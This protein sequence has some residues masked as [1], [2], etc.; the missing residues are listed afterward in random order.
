M[1]GNIGL[2]FTTSSPFIVKDW[3][4]SYTQPDYA[5]TGTIAARTVVIPPGPV[6]LEPGHVA[7]HSLEPQLRKLGMPTKLN[8]GVPTLE[9]EYEICKEGQVLKPDQVNLLKLFNILMAQ[10]SFYALLWKRCWLYGYKVSN[11]TYYL[12]RSQ[13]R[14][15]H[16]SRSSQRWLSSRGLD[17]S[18][19]CVLLV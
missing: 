18:T 16:S 8:K 12:S 6:E 17:L 13:I 1:K 5:R 11:Q 15:S 10:V 7:P 19:I 4:D 14:Y 2:L 3:F 9:N